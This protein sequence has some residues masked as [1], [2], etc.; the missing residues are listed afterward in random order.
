MNDVPSHS[1]RRS[2]M[3]PDT[4]RETI[5]EHRRSHM[6]LLMDPGGIRLALVVGIDDGS[7]GVGMACP[8]RS[9]PP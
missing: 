3:S 8:L 4:G 6:L 7:A 5:A 2:T 1:A 9:G